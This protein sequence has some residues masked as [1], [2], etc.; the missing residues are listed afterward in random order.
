MR[1][2]VVTVALTLCVNA[3]AE[4]LPTAGR[5]RGDPAFDGAAAGQLTPARRAQLDVDFFNEFW[6][7]SESGPSSLPSARAARIRAMAAEGFEVAYLADRLYNFE[8]N[9]IPSF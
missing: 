9:G 6:A 7:K 4:A 3:C 1:N 8:R 2:L 5:A